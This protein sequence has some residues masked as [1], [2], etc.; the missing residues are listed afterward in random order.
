M[1]AACTAQATDRRYDQAIIQGAKEGV[2]A[3]HE[4]AA[5]GG[6]AGSIDTQGAGEAIGE[7][8][9]QARQAADKVPALQYTLYAHGAV[10]VLTTLPQQ[11]I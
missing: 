5:A 7:G 9:G 11:C 3:Q 6:D 10:I 8:V 4:K 2:Q 1:Q